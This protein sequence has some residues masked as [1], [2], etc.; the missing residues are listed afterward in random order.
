MVPLSQ[1]YCYPHVCYSSNVFCLY[2][3]PCRWASTHPKMNSLASIM[4]CRQDGSQKSISVAKPPS[5]RLL[6]LLPNHRQVI[7]KW[8]LL[9]A[10]FGELAETS[11]VF[12]SNPALMDSF[13]RSFI[14][15]F[16]QD[17]NIPI[18]NAKIVVRLEDRSSKSSK[19]ELTL[20]LL[21]NKQALL[22]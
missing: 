12:T 3:L 5:T 1:M 7:R 2:A 20:C 15:L 21:A 6:Q 19:S 17:T 13:V 9:N 4:I 18:S 16:L 22:F 11:G 14:Q 10:S 8:T